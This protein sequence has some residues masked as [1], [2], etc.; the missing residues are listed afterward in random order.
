MTTHL[1]QPT[2]FAGQLFDRATPV[3]EVPSRLRQQQTNEFAFS[4]FNGEHNLPAPSMSP[5][6]DGVHVAV[7]DVDDLGPWLTLLGGDIRRSPV[8]EGRTMWVL[9]TSFQW[10]AGTRV[11]VTV[12]A[13]TLADELVLD[14]IRKAVR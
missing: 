4:V 11:P 14:Y 3:T 8:F 5:R 1:T 12:T 6:A 10:I 13:S 7:A 2:A 9:S